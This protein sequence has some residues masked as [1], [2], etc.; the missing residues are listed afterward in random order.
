M[1]PIFIDKLPDAPADVVIDG[2]Q[3]TR[4]MVDEST[5]LTRELLKTGHAVHRAS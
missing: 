2:K 4:A 1:E 5:N 3:M